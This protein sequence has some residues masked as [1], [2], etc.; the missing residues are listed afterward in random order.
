MSAAAIS[1]AGKI[2][3]PPSRGNMANIGQRVQ[4]ESGVW[5][6]EA[7]SEA[8]EPACG[9]HRIERGAVKIGI[10]ALDLSVSMT[11]VI[12]NCTILPL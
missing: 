8:S 4:P 9:V 3:R 11:V 5:L 2:C 1:R 6:P 10:S 7:V 12:M